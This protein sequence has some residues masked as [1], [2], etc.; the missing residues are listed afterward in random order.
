[1]DN[2]AIVF[3]R[4]VLDVGCGC[5][6]G[7]IAASSV[8]AKLAVANDIDSCKLFFSI[9]L[10]WQTSDASPDGRRLP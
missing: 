6:A 4:R 10:G 7:A 2:P 9:Q 5:G 8:R 1:M 3:G